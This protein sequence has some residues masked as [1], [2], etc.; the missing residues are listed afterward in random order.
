MADFGRDE[1]DDALDGAPE[2]DDDSVIDDDLAT[3]DDGE[4]F[5]GRDDSA[6]A[7]N[8]DRRPAE[9]KDVSDDDSDTN[10]DTDDATAGVERDG[11]ESLR[12]ILADIRR[13]DD[14]DPRPSELHT[15][16]AKTEIATTT[17]AAAV[18]VAAAVGVG[19]YVV[20]GTGA[21]AVVTLVGVGA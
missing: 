10:S 8:R 16:E 3:P 12:E 17:V 21:L 18:L 9:V 1:I 20:A 14:S 5:I 6:P 2:I 13:L 4:A 7:P 11:D 15:T 19:A